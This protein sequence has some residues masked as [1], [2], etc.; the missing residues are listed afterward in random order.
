MY[1]MIDAIVGNGLVKPSAT[2]NSDVALVSNRI[3]SKR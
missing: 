2:F 3:A 1:N